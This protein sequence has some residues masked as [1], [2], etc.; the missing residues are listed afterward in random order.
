VL[1]NKDV[2]SRQQQ[3]EEKEFVFR[4]LVRAAYAED[5]HPEVAW[6]G[7]IVWSRSLEGGRHPVLGHRGGNEWCYGTGGIPKWALE[8]DPDKKV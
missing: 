8:F 7:V 5:K 1:T 4:D 2:K 3:K 6:A